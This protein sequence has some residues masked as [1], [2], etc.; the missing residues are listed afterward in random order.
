MAAI[1]CL[2][3]L[4]WTTMVVSAGIGLFGAHR[5]AGAAAD[6]AALAGALDHD[7]SAAAR[8]AQANGAQLT[9]CVLA[10]GEVTVEVSVAGPTLFGHTARLDARARAG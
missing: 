9:S 5:R 8:I 2:V 6:L 10:G 7:C 1:A 4:V 3:A